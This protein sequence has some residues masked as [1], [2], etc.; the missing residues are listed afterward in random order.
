[1]GSV[2]VRLPGDLR[3]GADETLLRTLLSPRLQPHFAHLPIH[4]DAPQL[5]RH[6][7]Y[8]LRPHYGT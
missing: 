6:I 5:R 8:S 7:A 3:V 2:H 4:R 1:M